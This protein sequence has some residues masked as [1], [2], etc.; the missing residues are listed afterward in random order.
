MAV[1]GHNCSLY[2]EAD[3][4]P[5]AFALWVM[6]VE[7]T[8]NLTG[9]SAQSKGKKMFYPRAYAPG[10]LSVKGRVRDEAELQR[11][12]LFIRKHQRNLINTPFDERF[13]RIHTDN[14]GY[15]R[16]MRISIPTE[17]IAIRGWIDSFSVAK[18]GYKN[19]APEFT[20]DFFVVFDQTAVDIGISSRLQKYYDMDLGVIAKKPKLFV[21]DRPAQDVVGDDPG[22]TRFQDPAADYPGRN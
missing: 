14:P 5:D 9:T 13:A 19:V 18:K 15:K 16:L 2:Y 8:H 11:L 1:L 17:G 4:K 20:F 10:D 21:E 22:D 7:Q 6:G 12:A 3:G